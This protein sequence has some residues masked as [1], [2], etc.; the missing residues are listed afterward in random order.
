MLALYGSGRQAEALATYRQARQELAVELGVSPSLQLRR[1]HQ[2]VLHQSPL[3][4][5]REGRGPALAVPDPMGDDA[6]QATEARVL[7]A[8]AH[9]LQAQGRAL[10]AQADTLLNQADT[11]QGRADT[12]QGRAGALAARAGAG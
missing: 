11:P 12:P 2:L 5:P 10:S 6:G 8:R 1:L 3:P 4:V 7:L 9:A